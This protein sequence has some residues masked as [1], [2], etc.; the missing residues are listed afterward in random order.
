MVAAL[1]LACDGGSPSPAASERPRVAVS[2]FPLYDIARRVAGDRLDVVCVLPPGRSEHGYDPSPRE[3]A[4][5]SGAR[6]G[7]LVGLEMDGWAERIVR[8]AATSA[9]D[10]LV[11][12]P[13]VSPRRMTAH[14]VGMDLDEH[15]HDDGD[16]HD[17]DDHDGDED[18]DH[19][20]HDEPGEH[21]EEA[22]HHDEHHHHHGAEDPHFWLDPVRM[23]DAVGAMVEAFSRLDPEGASGYAERGATVRA[24]LAALHTELEGR[25]RALTRRTVV[26]FHGSFGYFAERYR[27]T[28]AAVIEPFPGRE[29]TP[30]YVQEVIGAIRGSGAAALFSE[31]QLDPRAARV[32]AAESGVALFELDPIGGTGERVTYEALLRANATVLER[33]LR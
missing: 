10:M 21:H 12:G 14:E 8:G 2:I 23:Q 4:A 22:G 20:E 32:I 17:G 16:D 31:P 6:L 11:L 33:A 18:G 3:M 25:M 28:I 9:P 15:D 1:A 26:T 30:R 24:A 7:V 27:L 13:R 29:P 19:D 5:V